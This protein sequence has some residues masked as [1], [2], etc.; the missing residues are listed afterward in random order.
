MFCLLLS[1]LFIYNSMGTIDENALQ[2]INLILN[3][4]LKIKVKEKKDK[5]SKEEISDV[6]PSFIWVLRDAFLSQ[7]D[8]KGNKLSPKEYLENSLKE[9]KGMSNTIYNK[10]KIRNNIKKYFPERECIRFVRPVEDESLLKNL[11][12][13][14]D[15]NLRKNFLVQVNNARKQ[16][17]SNMKPKT[18]CGQ[19]MNPKIIIELTKTYLT[20]INEHKELNI[21]S[22]WK[23]VVRTQ[24]NKAKNEV[25]DMLNRVL[26]RINS[27][28]SS[29]LRNSVGENKEIEPIESFAVAAINNSEWEEWKLE[30]KEYL[31]K[32]F[33]KKCIGE[34]NNFQHIL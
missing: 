22:S 11:D 23:Y 16:I 32:L 24:A 17:F 31:L 27:L 34:E 15:N 19:L 4:A 10:N 21:E 12:K 28:L 25:I 3:L 7:E 26:N 14:S 20:A 6:F 9:Q 5:A 8:L 2:N 1:S 13:V 30:F 29:G 18:Y 33:R